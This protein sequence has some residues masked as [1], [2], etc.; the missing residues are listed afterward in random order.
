VNIVFE[1]GE[2]SL[3]LSMGLFDGTQAGS[4]V[5]VDGFR[6]AVQWGIIYNGIDRCGDQ[7]MMPDM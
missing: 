7:F 2:A 4:G 6:A 1:H 5:V 3:D